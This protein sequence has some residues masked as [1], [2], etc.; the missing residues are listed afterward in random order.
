MMDRISKSL[1]RE[2]ELIGKEM[3][4]PKNHFLKTATPKIAFR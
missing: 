1:E 4:F 3:R 2:R